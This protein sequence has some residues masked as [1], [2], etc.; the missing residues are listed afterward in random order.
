MQLCK[1]VV[2]ETIQLEVQG[3]LQMYHDLVAAEAI[4][5]KAFRRKFAFLQLPPVDESSKA[6]TGRGRIG[7]PENPHMSLR[8]EQMCYWLEGVEDGLYTLI[9]LQ[10]KLRSLSDCGED[11]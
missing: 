4:C 1:N 7:R 3:H 9:E 2:I 10:E 11:V 5:H 8:F 6:E